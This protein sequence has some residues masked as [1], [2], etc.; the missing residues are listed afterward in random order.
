[1]GRRSNG[2]VAGRSLPIVWHPSYEVDL[3]QHVFPTTKYRLVRERLIGEHSDQAFE[4]LTPKPATDDSIALVHT[5]EYLRKIK[6][7][8]LTEE[9]RLAL[10]MPF[11]AK[12]RD[13]MWLCTGGTTLTCRMAL[14][15][16]VAV[17]LGGGFH[18]A[19]ADHGE[20][21]CLINDVAV[22]I[23]Q[24]TKEGAIKRSMVVD[25]S[26]HQGN[27]TAAIFADDDAVF[28]FSMHQHRNYPAVKPSGDLDIGL[29]DR[30]GDA[31]Y[32]SHLKN[33][34]PKILDLHKPDLVVYLA[35]ADPYEDDQLGD[36]WLTLDGLRRRDEIVMDLCREAGIPVAVTLAGGYANRTDDTVGIHCN[37]VRAANAMWSRRL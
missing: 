35:G 23:R 15:Q 3:G 37:T 12:L 11:S 7:G 24:L 25:L 2:F 1:M 5:S 13:A 28:T 27:G 20:G 14:K 18:H 4:F 29:G 32:Q 10:E 9:E 8:D 31:A 19:F 33:Q 22:A 26:V 36:L 34:L 16:G 21:F 6:T 17:H 30:T